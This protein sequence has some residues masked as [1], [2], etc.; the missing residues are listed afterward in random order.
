L[1]GRPDGRVLVRG[2]LQ[3]DDDERQAVDEQHHVGPPL[4]LVLGNR[5]LVDG[6]EVVVGRRGA[7]DQ[8][9]LGP[10]DSPPIAGREAGKALNK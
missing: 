2:V 7:V 9:R 3:L 4:A 5:E 8:S 10:G 6:Q 1:A